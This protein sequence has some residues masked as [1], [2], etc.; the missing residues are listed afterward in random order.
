MSDVWVVTTTWPS[1][2]DAAGA[3]QALVTEGLA[4]CAQVQGPLASTFHWGGKVDHATEWFCHLKTTA[5]RYPALE[6]RIRA[7]HSYEVPEIVAL[8]VAAGNPAY[9]AWVRATLG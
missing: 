7:L 4:A 9:L 1:E 2:A 5:E 8:P 3:A 6:S